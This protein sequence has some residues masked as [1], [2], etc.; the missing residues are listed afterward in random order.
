MNSASFRRTLALG[1]MTGMRSMS[2]PATLA[3]EHDGILRSVV[4]LLAAAEMIGDKTSVV[5]DRIDPAPLAGRAIMGAIV[6]GLVARDHR[7]NMAT[8]SLVGAATA[9][10]AAH[11]AFY[12][13]ERLPLPA[14]LA[15]IFE[16]AVVLGLASAQA[17]R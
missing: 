6:G 5:G 3:L 9:V 12:I 7:Q 4:L 2:G 1:A 11:L 8:G 16:D 17:S 14:A 15:G 10:I 13:R